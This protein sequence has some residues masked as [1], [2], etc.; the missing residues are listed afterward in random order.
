MIQI[1]GLT[2]NK[3]LIYSTFFYQYHQ[4]E[5]LKFDSAASYLTMQHHA[6]PWNWGLCP[7]PSL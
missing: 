4:F 3:R 2:D 7:G 5:S 1:N 6:W